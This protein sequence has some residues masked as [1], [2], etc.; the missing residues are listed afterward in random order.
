MRFTISLFL[1]T[2]ALGQQ[3]TF[4]VAS[5]KP[6]A[7][8]QEIIS[9]DITPDGRFTARNLTVR[10][11]IRFAFG[12]GELQLTGGPGWIASQGFDIQAKPAES[13]SRDQALPMMQSLLADRF[14]LKFHRETRQQPGYALRL[15][16][17]EA[18]LP[19]PREG[20]SSTRFGDFDAAN[21]TL[22]SFCQILEFELERPVVNETGLNGPYAIKLQWTSERIPADATSGKPSLFTALQ[23]QLGLKLESARVPVEMF[24]I[25]SVDQP[26]EN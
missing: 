15:A 17:S 14:H 2:A 6:S 7:P 18:K 1:A 4:E 8:G 25:D 12:L 5:V 20:R 13:V 3:P 26:S 22:S 9:W 24:V 11:L 16:K 23:E 10:N 21:Q 19:P